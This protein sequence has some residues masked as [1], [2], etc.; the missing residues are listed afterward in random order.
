MCGGSKSLQFCARR[1]FAPE[2][3]AI[4]QM[5]CF[6]IR[7]GRGRNGPILIKAKRNQKFQGQRKRIRKVV[8]LALAL[9][10]AEE[11]PLYR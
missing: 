10:L 7:M 4:E 3:I 6:G 1:N 2:F 5:H 9:A 8:A 11:E